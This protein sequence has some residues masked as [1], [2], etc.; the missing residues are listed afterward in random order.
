[1]NFWSPR[2]YRTSLESTCDSFSAFC[3]QEPQKVDPTI[4]RKGQPHIDSVV[5]SWGNHTDQDMEVV[6]YQEITQ[7]KRF[8]QPLIRRIYPQLIADK[9][10]SVQP[11]QG[12]A[13]LVHYLRHRN[14]SDNA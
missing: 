11:L 10:V 12:P 3:G 4:F 14:S 7:F 1:M 6:N 8:S 9:I 13:S 5:D 2:S